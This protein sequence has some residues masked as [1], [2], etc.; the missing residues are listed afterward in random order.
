[1]DERTEYYAEIAKLFGFVLNQYRLYSEKHPASQLAVANFYARLELILASE[2]TLTLGFV[3]GRLLANDHAIDGKKTGVAELLRESHRLHLESLVFERG[4]TEDEISSFFRVLA[5]PPRILEQRGG[6]AE[7]FDGEALPHV[8]LGTARYRM[9]TDEEEVVDKSKIGAGEGRNGDAG[10]EPGRKIER[11]SDLVELC[12]A[13]PGGE[14]EFDFGRLIYELEKKPEVA[15]QQVV[16]QAK[17]LPALKRIIDGLARF[18]AEQLIPLFIQD[19]KDFSPAITRLARA[20]KKALEAPETPEEFKEAAAKLTSVLERCADLI[21][22]ELVVRAFEQN[23]GDLSS[24]AK[25]ADKFLRSREVRERLGGPLRERLGRLGVGDKDIEQL[26]AEPQ[27][28]RT[29]MRSRRVEISPE[30]FEEFSRLKHQFEEKLSQRVQEVTATIEREKQKLIND[31]ERVDSV[32]RNLAAGLVVVDVEGKIQVMNPAAEKLLG[33][34]QTEGK[35][36]PIPQVLKD[37]HMLALAK[38]PLTDA[39]D[40]LTKEIELRSVD[41]ETR[42]VLQA[43]SAVIENEEGKTVGMVSVLNDITKQKALDEAKSKFVAHVS[44]ELRTP[45]VAIDESLAILMR[46]EVGSVSPEQEKFLGIARRNISRLSRLVNDLLDVAKLEAGKI[47]LRPVPFQVKDLVHHVVETV[48]GWA[49][50]R[51]ISLEE[52]YP[53][54]DVALE[55]DP[56]RLIQVVTNLLGNAIKF[57]PQS[58]TVAVEVDDNWSDREMSFE[59]CVAISVQDSGIGIPEKDQ[60]RIFKKFEQ[61]SLVSPEG[62]SSTGLGL[63]I[64]KE[65][66]ALHG[67]RIWVDSKEGEGSRFTFAIPKRF[68]DRLK[69]GR[70]SAPNHAAS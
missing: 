33:L 45:L 44:H 22:L 54:E 57:S 35:G 55:A 56:D 68:K 2:P 7:V 41:D 24:F 32:I 62:M 59:A 1:M 61:I 43:S 20:L 47:D 18:V 29:P 46:E 21:K 36:V 42:R 66:V 8:R 28:G 23:E 26:L 39:D 11:V 67:G 53:H 64:A 38:G 49:N 5:M 25:V 9:V 34:N 19:G 65:I 63:T 69:P 30:E 70:S 37:E 6:L 16:E 40:R 58:G 51:G 52:K 27:R 48:R 3:G 15:V 50:E 17:D 4:I 10:T 12:L 13:E 31:K 14:I 60:E